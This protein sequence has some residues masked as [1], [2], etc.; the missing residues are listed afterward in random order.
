MMKKIAA[1]DI[2]GTT[3]IV[4]MVKASKPSLHVYNIS[5]L[6]N[7]EFLKLY[8]GTAEKS[9]GGEIESVTVLSQTEAII[10]FVDPTGM[11]GP[12]FAVVE[13]TSSII[14]QHKH[15]HTVSLV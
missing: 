2:D 7:E 13:I 4:E 11:Y 14:L 10:T 15:V 12:Q 1:K 5:T 8:F 9:G 6:C 3:V